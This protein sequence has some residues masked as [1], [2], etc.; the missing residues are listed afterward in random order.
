MFEIL[1]SRRISTSFGIAA[2]AFVL[3][4]CTG[5]VH[6]VASV[7]L[8]N[9]KNGPK[10]NELVLKDFKQGSKIEVGKD[11]Y[12]YYNGDGNGEAVK[13]PLEVISAGEGKF[14]LRIR[15]GGV[16]TSYTDPEKMPPQSEFT[17]I[18][19]DQSYQITGTAGKNG[20]TRLEV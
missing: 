8:L 4:G 10:S 18:D 5:K 2:G 6:G 3:A 16:G 1:N 7:E 11:I 20:S 19:E 12:T 15:T 17:F 9:C 14:L 13:G